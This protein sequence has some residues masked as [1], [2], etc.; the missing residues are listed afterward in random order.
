[1]PY[2]GVHV[3]DTTNTHNKGQLSLVLNIEATLLL[4]VTLEPDQILLL[5]QEGRPAF[6]SPIRTCTPCQACNYKVL[7]LLLLLGV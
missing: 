5:Q 1:M 6:V 2:L 7:P 3:I 4:S